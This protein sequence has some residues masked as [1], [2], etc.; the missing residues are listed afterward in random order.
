MLLECVLF[1]CGFNPTLCR[2]WICKPVLGSVEVR[3]KCERR[4]TFCVPTA[5][6]KRGALLT[7]CIVSKGQ[8]DALLLA[9]GS[10]QCSDGLRARLESH[11]TLA[12]C[13]AA[14]LKALP[15]PPPQRNE[16]I[17][18]F[19]PGTEFTSCFARGQKVQLQV[20]R[21]HRCPVGISPGAI[22]TG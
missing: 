2:V 15:A 20:L 18:E 13:P 6:E 22:E 12:T 19:A 1:L 17:P 10:S 8:A 11:K 4:P 21:A 9:Q 14:A 7:Q 3:R 5:L 16:I